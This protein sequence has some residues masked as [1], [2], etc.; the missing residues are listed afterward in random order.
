M[1]QTI[2]I[3]L[4]C[5]LLCSVF[6]C[7]SQSSVERPNVIIVMTDDQGY[8]DLSC[9][10]NP[11]IKTPNLDKLHSQSTRFTNFHVDPT[12]APTRAALITGRYSIRTGVWH[13]IAGR[14]FLR[15]DEVTLGDVFKSNGY[16]TGMFGKWHL[17]DNYP[18]RPQDRG[19]DETINHGGGG[20]GQTPDLWGNDYFD[21]RYW[22][23]GKPQQY[24]GYCT[25]VFFGGALEFIGKNKDKPF[26]C[27]LLPNAPHGP[28]LVP[29]FYAKPYRDRGIP[30][31]RAK[32]YGMLSN[33]D[34]NMGLLLAKLD[35]LGLSENTIVVFMTDN[36]TAGPWYPKDGE[37]FSAGL[38]GIK[39][40]IYEGGHRVPS[41][42]R[43][44]K[45]GIKS[46]VD[47]P[48]VAAHIDMMP[49]LV[50]MCGLKKRGGPELDGSSLKPLLAGDASS[51]KERTLIV[52]NQR[53]PVPEKY[54]NFSVMTDRWRLVNKTELYDMDADL[55][56]TKNVADANPDVVKQLMQ[57]YEDWWGGVTRTDEVVPAVVGSN[58]ENPSILTAHD[59][60]AS[61]IPWHQD[62]V[63]EA[64][65][66]EGHWIVDIERAGD[67]EITLRQQPTEAKF[68]I[69]G[70]NAQL[71][72]G[73][74]DVSSPIKAG[75]TSVTFTVSLQKGLTRIQGWFTKGEKSRGAYYAY[76]RRLESR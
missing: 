72:V 54:R 25:D 37:D 67:Y 43:W 12:C 52:N 10:G 9:H 61:K 7:R 29:D 8:G 5:T 6:G 70:D 33:I 51:W 75:D 2:R 11:D 20:V 66:F 44:P 39:G 60:H 65:L 4:A 48:D 26:F 3:F 53:I 34:D 41:F 46:G 62:V 30:D 16:A 22:H 19:F 64:P 40:S 35:D 45:G 32:F 27:Y 14:S 42:W 49:T 15:R 56:Q 73:D 23:N 36:G 21:D 13:T 69:E 47:V 31:N 59:W 58:H 18:C 74:V 71:Q 55:G 38:R 63:A 57:S 76:V 17:G 68:Q 50:D 1:K 24:E 28:Y